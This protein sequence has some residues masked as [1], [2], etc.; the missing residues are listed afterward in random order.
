[1]KD[2]LVLLRHF[3]SLLRASARRVEG[4][5][6]PACERAAVGLKVN[7]RVAERVRAPQLQ[8]P[9]EAQRGALVEMWHQ[10]VVDPL[11]CV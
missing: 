9:H 1:M 2:A 5:W 3:H 4:G 6:E 7:C 8:G 11:L 10:G